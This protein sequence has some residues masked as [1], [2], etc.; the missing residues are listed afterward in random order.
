MNKASY[1]STTIPAIKILYNSDIIT[2]I[3]NHK[4]VPYHVKVCPTNKCP[5]RCSMCTF[6]NRDTSKEIEYESLIEK[7]NKLISLGMKA[8]TLS[9]GG[10]PLA[11]THIN[12]YINY[13]ASKGIKIGLT[14]N[15][16]LFRKIKD[17]NINKLV[18]CRISATDEYIIGK[19]TLEK[20]LSH[21]VDWA[22]S[23]IVSDITNVGDLAELIKLI[24]KYENF[25]HIR[26]VNNIIDHSTNVFPKIKKELDSLGID[27]SKV[28]YQETEK[29]KHGMCR[30]LSSL[31]T[32]VITPD[33]ALMPCC[34]VTYAKEPPA[35]DWPEE[36]SMGTDI[37]AIYKDQKYF[38]GSKCTKCYQHARNEMLSMVWDLEKIN[39]KD[40]I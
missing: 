37:D 1:I 38:D 35:L 15:G 16:L 17:E 36:F 27:Q 2:Q 34:G 18:W 21:N 30:C 14:T 28:I 23:Y 32:P 6:K 5:I 31:L 8:I 4:I 26:L 3:I 40:F 11:Y 25:T 19:K 20:L 39:H 29:F 10:E 7:T 12:E 22:F 33:G 24:N 13:T 9:G